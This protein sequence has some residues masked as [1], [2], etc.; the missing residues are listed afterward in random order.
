M[1]EHAEK[2][3]CIFLKYSA[4]RTSVPPAQGLFVPVF[5]HFLSGAKALVILWGSSGLDCGTDA[6]A[7]RLDGS[8]IHR[9]T[10]ED[11]SDL[12]RMLRVS[13]ARGEHVE[14]LDVRK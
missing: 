3:R 11:P 13:R 10:K 6:Y 12:K 14:P 4:Q 2:H 5:G 9:P 8:K 1:P 7:K